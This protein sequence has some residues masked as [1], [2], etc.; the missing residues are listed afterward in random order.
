MGCL[1]NSLDYVNGHEG[2]GNPKRAH[3]IKWPWGSQLMPIGTA[4]ERVGKTVDRPAIRIPR[5]PFPGLLSGLSIE[6]DVQD[7]FAGM[8]IGQ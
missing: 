1:W 2:L 5:E 7:A 4:M 3:D 8:G 6:A